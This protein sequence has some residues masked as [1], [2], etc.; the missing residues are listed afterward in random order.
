MH[1]TLLSFLLLLS[2]IFFQACNKNTGL[3][4]EW[5]Q[6]TETFQPWIV[7]TENMVLRLYPK[8]V[9]TQYGTNSYSFGKWRINEKGG[10]IHLHQ[11][12]GTFE[13]EDEYLKIEML[14]AR[15]LTTAAFYAMPFYSNQQQNLYRFKG[16]TNHSKADPYSPE[17][18]GWRKQPQVP[19]APAN[20]KKR[21]VNY[22]HFVQAVYQHAIDNDLESINDYWYPSPLRMHY[23]NGVRMAYSNELDDWNRCFYDSAQAVKG[24]QIISG[25]LYDVKLKTGVNHFERN[26]D[27]VDQILKRLEK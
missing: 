18:N 27:C 17:M 24:Y 16:L 26:L 3:I 10:Y 6:T 7:N 2:C 19:E 1:R 14:Q 12:A 22:L 23:G 4:G 15:R 8:G 9:Y 13:E 25:E 21:V 5:Y 20:I 11:D